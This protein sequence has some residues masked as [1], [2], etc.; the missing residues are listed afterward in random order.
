MSVS[1]IEG[2][3]TPSTA[4]AVTAGPDRTAI[5]AN[6]DLRRLLS[7][8]HYSCAEFVTQAVHRR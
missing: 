2:G 4:P 5:N 6:A 1:S 7:I 3:G 8:I